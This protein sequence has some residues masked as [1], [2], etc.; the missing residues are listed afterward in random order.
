MNTEGSVSAH[1]NTLMDYREKLR[2]IDMAV[3]V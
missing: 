2:P 1:L 3:K